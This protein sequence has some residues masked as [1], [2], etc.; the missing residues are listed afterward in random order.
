MAYTASIV[1]LTVSGS[2]V[3][4]AKAG[5]GVGRV[6]IRV[7]QD[8]RMSL[9]ENLLDTSYLTLPSGTFLVLAPP[10]LLAY[11]Q[12]FFR[13]DDTGGADGTVELLRC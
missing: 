8:T 2:N 3:E 4:S 11:E 5:S 1:N 9:H 7:S 12:L 13:L 10:N 6:I